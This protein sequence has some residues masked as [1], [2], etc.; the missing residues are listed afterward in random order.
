MSD[1]LAAPTI[2]E[3]QSQL[4]FRR[5]VTSLGQDPDG[6]WWGG[7]VDYEWRHLRHTL[8]ASM[9][10]LAGKSVLELGCNIGASAIVMAAMGAHVTA[11]DVDTGCVAMAKANVASYGTLAGTASVRHCADTRATGIP[12]ASMDLV[13]CNSVLEYVASEQFDGICLEIDRVLKPGGSLLVIG[14]SN[15]L[16][17]REV[18]SGEWFLNWMPTAW[19]KQLSKHGAKWQPG[20]TPWRLLR[21][22]PGYANRDVADGGAAFVAARREIGWPSDRVRV[23][24]AAGKV[25]AYAGVSLGCLGP[26][27]SVHLE[28][29]PRRA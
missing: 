18:H 26:N 12:S 7:Y 2:Q 13:L 6:L 4:A 29:R 24:A 27:L 3:P 20:I 8:S 23:A 17:P 21:A 11:I 10:S 5:L 16:W 19:A 28:K 1:S 25:L 14:T 15:R 9:G 22:F